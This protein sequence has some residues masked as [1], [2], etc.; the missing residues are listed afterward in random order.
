MKKWT[1]W[2][3][4]LLIALILGGLGWQQY[5]TQ[6]S[7]STAAPAKTTR[8]K[9]TPKKA[10]KRPTQAKAWIKLKHPLKLPIL[11]YHS[12]SSGNQLR[13]PAKQF[14]QEMVYL[15][16]H[17]YRTLTT[18]E[19]IRAFN[20]NSIPQK[21]VVWITLDDAYKDNLRSALPILKQEHL[22]GTINV[23]T[24]FTHRK[25][26]LSLAEM[27]KMKATN[28]VD[29][30]SHTVQHLDLN[31]LTAAQQKKELVNSK[32]WLDQHLNQDTQMLCYP[33]GRA[34]ATTRKLAKQAGYQL[35]LTTQEGLA[36][37]SQGRYNL[38]RLRITPGMT[39]AT[40]AT[41]LQV[42]NS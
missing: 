14:K 24:G 20:T 3:T 5:H 35:A 10:K 6:Q 18:A 19:A 25:N 36:T 34:N 39:T 22:H 33:A 23:I 11:M 15:R 40:F 21:K 12:I 4:G 26:H 27:L 16:R 8:S 28:N 13:V 42:N 9:T 37:L 7:R 41:L 31:E 1:I 32:T 30:E 2:G 17:H 29:F 38:A